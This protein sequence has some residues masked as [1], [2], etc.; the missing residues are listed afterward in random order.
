M[1]VCTCLWTGN[2]RFYLLSSLGGLIGGIRVRTHC[3]S[4]KCLSVDEID[5]TL[6]FS[7][8]IAGRKWP[9]IAL[10]IL[11]SGFPSQDGSNILQSIFVVVEQALLLCNDFAEGLKL[12]LEIV[13]FGLEHGYGIVQAI[14]VSPGIREPAGR[15]AQCRG[16]PC[17][18]HCSLGGGMHRIEIFA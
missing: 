6:D 17:G 10:S 14:K 3:R 2:P 13:L 12:G 5:V 11:L 9:L 8:S 7:P 4:T 15:I 16:R 1:V 18:S